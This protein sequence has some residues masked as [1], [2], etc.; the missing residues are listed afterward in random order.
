MARTVNADTEGKPTR[1]VY[2]RE[3]KWARKQTNRKA[4][5][6]AREALATMTDP[7]AIVIDRNPS[8]GGWITH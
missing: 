3:R 2:S 1:S 8:T 4:R 5:G 6:R 7:D